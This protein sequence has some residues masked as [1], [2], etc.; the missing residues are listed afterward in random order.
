MLPEMGVILY[1]IF[2]VLQYGIEYL[3]QNNLNNTGCFLAPSGPGWV[4]ENLVAVE[5]L[6]LYVPYRAKGPRALDQ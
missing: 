6:V 5:T 1:K 3:V 2:D 4:S